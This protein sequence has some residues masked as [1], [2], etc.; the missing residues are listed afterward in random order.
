MLATL[1][2]GIAAGAGA[3]YAEEPIKNALESVLLA[4]TPMTAMEL[5]MFSFAILLVGAAILAWIMGNG[6]G[7]A[8]A[9]GAAIGVFGP[10]IIARVQ[11]RQVPDYGDDE[12]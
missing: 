11:K 7:V 4:D 1:I 2:L 6:S 9:I 3:P 10:R 8:L 5:R 12:A